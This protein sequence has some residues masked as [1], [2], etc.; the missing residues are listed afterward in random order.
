MAA[1]MCDVFSFCVGVAG[2]AGVAVE[3]R[4]V[5]SAKVRPRRTLREPPT[6]S[7][8]GTSPTGSKARSLEA[9]L[10]LGRCGSSLLAARRL[11][12]CPRAQASGE[13]TRWTGGSEVFVR[14]PPSRGTWRASRGPCSRCSRRGRG[15]AGVRGLGGRG[16]APGFLGQAGGLCCWAPGMVGGNMLSRGN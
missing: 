3:V 5:S 8:L 7:G 1:S 4:F 12:V 13:V 6:L 2:R 15:G 11:P 9:P 14:A 16:A 10:P